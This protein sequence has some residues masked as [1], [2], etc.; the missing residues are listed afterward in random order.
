MS[1]FHNFFPSEAHICRKRP[2]IC[3]K[4]HLCSS[5][6]EFSTLPVVFQ[7]LFSFCLDFMVFHGRMHVSF[8]FCLT[9]VLSPP[10]EMQ[11]FASLCGRCFFFSVLFLMLDFLIVSL[12][13]FFLYF[14]LTCTLLTCIVTAHSVIGTWPINNNK[15]KGII[16]LGVMWGGDAA[17]TGLINRKRVSIGK[18]PWGKR[19]HGRCWSYKC[20]SI[21]DW[22]AFAILSVS[23]HLRDISLKYSK[24]LLLYS[25][26]FSVTLQSLLSG[27]DQYSYGLMSSAV[28]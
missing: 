27:F 24:I 26:H 4:L 15:S 17:V 16:C 22:G 11:L 7:L 5:E 19:L 25:F 18:W 1:F 6:N 9:T 20:S 12:F 28:I 8:L 2:I 10:K 13:S 14:L 23:F 21:W 3:T